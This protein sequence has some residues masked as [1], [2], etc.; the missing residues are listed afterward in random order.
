[1]DEKQSSGSVRGL[2]KALED[3]NAKLPALPENVK[4]FIVSVAPWLIIISAI[5]MIPAILLIFGL[6]NVFGPITYLNGL[7]HGTTFYITWFLS[8]TAFLLQ[9][10]AIK[11]LMDKKI[12]AWRLVFY[13]AL[14]SAV[15]NLVSL[16]IASFI[17]GA[18]ISLYFLFQIKSYYK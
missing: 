18:A 10:A 11:G 1:M 5:A 7:Y 8:V 9:V 12:S 14:I 15:S 3:I 6:G 2:E 13:S 16:S 17:I 4:S